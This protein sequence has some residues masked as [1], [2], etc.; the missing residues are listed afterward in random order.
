ML[1]SITSATEELTAAV[2]NLAA[3]SIDC[4]TDHALGDD[5][6]AIRREIDRL[7]A[8]FIRRLHPFDRSHGALSEGAAS[9]V[10]WLR[11]T[12][13]LTGGAAAERVRMARVL[14]DLPLT[15]ESF[16]AGR[17]PFTNVSL[18]ARL[19][20]EVGA[21]S[22]RTVEPTLVDAAEKLDSARMYYLATFTRHRLDADGA[23]DK[24][25]QAH[26]RRWFSCDQ[27]FGG[28]FILRGELDAEGGALVKTALDALSSPSGPNDER[29]GS[30]RR[31]DALVDLASR[32]LQSGNLSQAHGQRPHLTLTASLQTLQRQDGAP[33]AELKTAGPIHAETARR[34]ACDSVRTSAT[35]SDHHSDGSALSVGRASRTIPAPIRTAL[36]P[37]DKG[38]RFPGCDRPLEWTDGHHIR[39]W[40]DGGETSLANLVLL[41]RRH[42]RM[43]HE[44]GWELKLD[45]QGTVSVREPGGR[46]ALVRRL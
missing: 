34:I 7:E 28:V 43:V 20:E 45:A 2:D 37:R 21:D 16:R 18:I 32:Q 38:C 23:L 33:P 13:G 29:N 11:A 9:T 5:L 24:D 8:Q 15:A 46:P 30:Q 3:E 27:T 44:R 41:C 39:H 19:A 6:V 26:D 10:S 31:A 17:A 35:V 25:N 12:C 14:D 40:A 1:A 42:H 22:A 36:G 4:A